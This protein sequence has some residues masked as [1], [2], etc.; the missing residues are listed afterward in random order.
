MA[1]CA[2]DQ[3]FAETIFQDFEKETGIKVRTIYD[4]EAVKTVGLANRLLAERGHPQCDVF[5]GNEE[6]RT[7]QLAAREV[8]RQTNGWAAFGARSRRIV[9]NTNFVPV[10]TGPRS[11]W[12]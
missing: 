10:A 5:W 11:C 1:Y 4:N 6:M 2:Q 12:N 7:R 3:V 9:V 8:F